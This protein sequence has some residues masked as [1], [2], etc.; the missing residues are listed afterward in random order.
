MKDFAVSFR[1]EPDLYA[2]FK[3]ATEQNH[4]PVAQ[5][6]RGFM[7]GYVAWA[8]QQNQPHSFVSEEE[9]QRRE[10]AFRNAEGSAAHEFPD[11]YVPPSEYFEARAKI[12]AGEMSTQDAL[13]E[14]LAPYKSG[15]KAV[16]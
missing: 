12:I 9:K 16:A 14:I 5:V 8:Q 11:D 2:E 3:R 10:A 1:V 4:T 7:R 6:L 15:A 13:D